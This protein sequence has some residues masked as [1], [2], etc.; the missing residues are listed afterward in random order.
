M[1]VRLTATPP[2]FDDS[3]GRILISRASHNHFVGAAGLPQ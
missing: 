2:V 3:L 1:V